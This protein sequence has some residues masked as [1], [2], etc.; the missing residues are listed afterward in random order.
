MRC[1]GKAVDWGG[2]DAAGRTLTLGDTH[3]DYKKISDAIKNEDI[4]YI[5]VNQKTDN[6]S[7]YTIKEFPVT[8]W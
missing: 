3:P 2:K 1:K 6:L 8:L 5:Y 4:A 7:N